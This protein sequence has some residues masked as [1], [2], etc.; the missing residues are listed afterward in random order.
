[1]PSE[2]TIQLFLLRGAE[3]KRLVLEAVPELADQV[4]PLVDRE[5]AD[6]VTGERH[7]CM[8]APS[9]G[10][11]S[12]SPGRSSLAGLRHPLLEALVDEFVEASFEKLS[13]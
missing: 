10:V 7:A 12:A 5:L 3:R 8:L 13:M 6:L 9:S 1:M 4:E 11:A 2:P